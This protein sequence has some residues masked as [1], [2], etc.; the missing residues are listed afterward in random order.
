MRA[1]REALREVVGVGGAVRCLAREMRV[2]VE[3][4]V[5]DQRGDRGDALARQARRH[6]G[7]GG[8]E[9]VRE[10]QQHVVLDRGNGLVA[11]AP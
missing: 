6:R 10:R 5:G 7:V 4:V 3:P 11:R 2:V 9:V 1:A 8:V